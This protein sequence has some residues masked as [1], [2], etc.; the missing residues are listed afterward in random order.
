MAAAAV[1]SAL[2]HR[3]PLTVLFVI[4]LAL[5]LAWSLSRPTDE[6]SLRQLPDQLEYLRIA[7]N[8]LKGSGLVF[9]DEGFQQ[10]VAAYRMPGYPLFV[11]AC[12]AKVT[13]VRVAQCAIDASCLLAVYA[14]ARPRL[15][16]GPALVA[17][18]FVAFNPYLVYFSSTLL[19][20]TLFG[21]LLIW[22]IVGLARG[23]RLAWWGGAAAVVASIYVR[24]SAI[25]LVPLLA[26]AAMLVRPPLPRPATRARRYFVL[27]GGLAMLLL[28]VAA[29]LPWAARNRG[30]LGAWVWTTTNTGVTA[31]DGLN[32]RADGSSNQSHFRNWT[33]L[34]LMGEVERSDYLS[35]LA[36]AY[37]DRTRRTSPNSPPASSRGC[38]R[39]CR[40]VRNSD[41]GLSM[42]RRG[43]L[44]RCRCSRSRSSGSFAAAAGGRSSCTCFC[45]PCILR[46]CIPRPSLAPLSR[47]GRRPDERRCRLGRGGGLG[48][49]AIA[50][51]TTSA[52]TVE[53]LFDR[54]PAAVL[55]R[56]RS[57]LRSVATLVLF[58]VLAAMIAAYAYVTDGRRVRENSERLLSDLLGG[59]VE[60]GSASLSIFEGLRLDD[61]RVFS[62]P[63]LDRQASGIVF[64]AKSLLV[65]YNPR[66][67]VVGRIEA[68]RILAL[69]PHV[70]LVE[71]LDQ[72][73]W[74]FQS[75]RPPGRSDAGHEAS[76][77]I[78]RIVLPEVLLATPSSI[79]GRSAAAC[80]RTSARSRSKGSLPPTCR[81]FTASACRAAAARAWAS[82]RSPRGGFRR[83][84]IRSA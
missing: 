28:T 56:R 45:R 60:V 58:V 38:G 40:S 21:G 7:Q 52:V 36:R 63:G 68:T 39:R 29:L 48:S 75:L 76:A 71:N 59:R 66:A 46:W 64:E 1:K 79:T 62:A 4:A 81:A 80:G 61:V 3:L 55:T 37:A 6:A 19:S 42:W 77:A 78:R 12:G 20:E 43:S 22:G 34:K 41:R 26:A 8:V 10:S 57:R 73:Q 44:M 14:L 5:R 25:A 31:Y 23:G 13:I 84:A 49:R 53:R 35:A 47:A 9:F 54:P 65:G 83:T 24:P 18:A 17:A 74:N 32:P 15:G 69:E 30:V 27:G 67:L 16:V 82:S 2:S 33:E 50:S 70:R 72:R 51:M 11:A